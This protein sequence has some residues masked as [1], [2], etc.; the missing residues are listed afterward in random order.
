VKST[1]RATH[2]PVTEFR[3]EALLYRGPDELSPKL[4]PMV[5]S[6][7]AAGD[8][9]L[10]AL[11][12]DAAGRLRALLGLDSSL[13]TF[14][15]MRDLGRNPARIIPVWRSFVAGQAGTGRGALGVGE[16]VW[17]GRSDDELEECELHESLLNVAFARGPAWRLVCPYDVVRLSES[18]IRT[19]FD[20]HPIVPGFPAAADP[21][22]LRN[23]PQRFHTP[24]A[25]PLVPADDVVEFEGADSLAHVRAMVSSRA[26]QVGLDR[27]RAT[28]LALA[29][30]EVAS[31]SVRYGGGGGALRIWHTLVALV[32]EVRDHG[33]IDDPLVGR[34]IPEPMAEGQRGLWLVNQMCD[35]VQLRSLDDGVVVRLHA[36]LPPSRA[37]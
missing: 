26:L 10:V 4:F 7:I 34:S 14:V 13:V 20:T 3:H 23:V 5:R 32:C 33:H 28:D 29:V 11:D 12:V 36:T 30:S 6:A 27:D 1:P 37:A 17:P 9:I 22:R 24:L 15:D 2:H 21:L 18:E 16:P 19:A 25:E 35:L 8:A 31:N